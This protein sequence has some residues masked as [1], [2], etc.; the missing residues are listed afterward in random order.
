MNNPTVTGECPHRDEATGASDHKY[1]DGFCIFC[2]KHASCE[3]FVMRD[4]AIY[5]LQE[6]A[7]IGAGDACLTL[8]DFIRQLAAERE[9]ISDCVSL[10]KK[11]RYT[12]MTVWP[13]DP[14]VPDLNQ[15]IRKL[16]KIG[17]KQ[18]QTLT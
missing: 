2:G 15:L 13:N 4:H 10:L 12:V 9:N 11:C 17:E 16:E 5:D 6:D 14:L 7:F 3:R 18:C 8:N 1:R